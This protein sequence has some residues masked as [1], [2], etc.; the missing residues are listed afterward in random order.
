MR[1]QKKKKTCLSNIIFDTRL[2]AAGEEEG[3]RGVGGG[4]NDPNTSGYKGNLFTA[5]DTAVCAVVIN[6]N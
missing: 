4:Q 1:K 6:A 5:A 2:P 3:E